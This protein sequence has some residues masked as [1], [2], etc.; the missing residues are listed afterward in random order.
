MVVT[1][2]GLLFAAGNDG[3]MRAFDAANWAALWTG[4]LPRG[5]RYLTV[6]AGVPLAVDTPVGRVSFALPEQPR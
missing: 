2:T 1:S 3:R 6:A 5:R 4:E